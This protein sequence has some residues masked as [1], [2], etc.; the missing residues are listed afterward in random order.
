MRCVFE[1]SMNRIL[2]EFCENRLYY[3]YCIQSSIEKKKNLEWEKNEFKN[4]DVKIPLH[5]PKLYVYFLYITLWNR[6]IRF[7]GVIE[8]WDEFINAYVCN[9]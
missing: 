6:A 9:K 1:T 4:N 5:V 3:R 7:Y 2:K 8:T